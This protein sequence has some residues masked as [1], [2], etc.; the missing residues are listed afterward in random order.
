MPRPSSLALLPQAGEG[1][2]RLPSPLVE[3]VGWGFRAAG[4]EPN[5]RLLAASSSAPCKGRG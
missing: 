2:I 4:G 1:N 5:Q 3:R